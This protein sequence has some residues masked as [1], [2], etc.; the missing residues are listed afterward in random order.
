MT[1]KPALPTGTSHQKTIV[2]GAEST[3][4]STIISFRS[5]SAATTERPHEDTASAPAIRYFIPTTSGIT[6]EE[7][8]WIAAELLPKLPQQIVNVIREAD[9]PSKTCDLLETSL[10]DDA[11][12]DLDGAAYQYYYIAEYYKAVHRHSAALF[13]NDRHYRALQY[14]QQKRK[15]RVHKGYPLIRM[16]EVHDLLGNHWLAER[17]LMLTLIEDAM[18]D[19]GMCKREGGVYWRIWPRKCASDTLLDA[20]YAEIHNEHASEYET[21]QWCPES[22]LPL[23]P[24]EWH[25]S[26]PSG[27]ECGQYH[28]NTSHLTALLDAMDSAGQ[29]DG[30]VLERTARYLMSCIP[31]SLVSQRRRTTATDYDVFCCFEGELRDFREELGRQWIC[32][33]K[34]VAESLSYGDVAKFARVLDSAKCRAGVLFALRDISGVE[35]RLYS[36]REIAK[37]FQQHGIAIIVI[38]REDLGQVAAGTNFLAILRRKYEKVRHDFLALDI[39]A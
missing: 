24:H 14:V 4:T 39:R 5:S 10:R 34:D 33:C 3:A 8:R 2:C 7:P 1:D 32:E 11:A 38:T 21:W 31:G 13:V 17:Y 19:N 15:A 16:S 26:R 25:V 18:Q 27:D 28:I 29:S 37:L 35:K 9:G 36:E 30:L 12:P 22:V 23:L 20:L 6:F